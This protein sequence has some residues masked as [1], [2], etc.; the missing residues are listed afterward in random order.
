MITVYRNGPFLDLCR[1]PH[2]PDTGAAEALQAAQRRRRLLARRLAAAD[3]A[4]HLRHGLVHAKSDWRRYLHAHGGGEEARPPPPRP[5]A[6]PLLLPPLRPRRRLLDAARHRSSTTQ[7]VEL[8]ARA[9][10]AATATRRSRRRCS[11]TRGCGRS[12]GHWGKYRENMF[13]VLDSET[14]EHDFSLKPMNCP[15][16]HLFYASKKH[17]YR[18]LPLRYAT[19]DVLHRN[20]VSGALCGPHPR[21]PVPAGRRAHLPGRGADRGRGAAAWW[22]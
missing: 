13:L 6:G 14:G 2:V 15:S 8:D 10:C 5:R 21:A 9:C 4:A 12:V 18:E 20:E 22:S 1:G 3:A 16:H 7:L 11:T 17:S 19:Q